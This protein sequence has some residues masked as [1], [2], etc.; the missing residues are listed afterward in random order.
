MTKLKIIPA[1]YITFFILVTGILVKSILDAKD[2]I[3]II[4]RGET[5]APVFFSLTDPNAE[6]SILEYDFQNSPSNYFV[7]Y[8]VTEGNKDS[9]VPVGSSKVDLKKYVGKNI[10]IQGSYKGR[11]SNQQ[12]IAGQCHKLFKSSVIDIHNITEK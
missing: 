5:T 8:K 7:T 3:D 9:S 6:Y 10:Q 1:L 11:I 2:A 12:C 4:F